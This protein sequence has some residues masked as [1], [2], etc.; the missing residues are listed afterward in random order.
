MCV[1][2]GGLE[3]HYT[4]LYIVGNHQSVLGSPE[5]EWPTHGVVWL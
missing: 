1:K 2:S 5:Q 4:V 3:F